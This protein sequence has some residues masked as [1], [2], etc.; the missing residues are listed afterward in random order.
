MRKLI[1][2]LALV[3]LLAG[4]AAVVAS[5]AQTK[6]VSWKVPSKSTVTIKKGGTVKWVWGDK[7]QHDVAGPGIKSPKFVTKK[8]HVFSKTFT[9]T[10]TFAYRCDVHAGS[11][12]TTVKV[13]K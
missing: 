9:K 6:T 3:A 2:T 8:G 11:M 7:K 5:A 13:T 4:L 10:G 12:K 1:A